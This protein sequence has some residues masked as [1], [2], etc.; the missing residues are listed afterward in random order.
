MSHNDIV[1][2]VATVDTSQCM[3][4]SPWFV[5]NTEYPPAV[6]TYKPLVNGEG[7][8][9]GGISSHRKGTK[10]GG[11]YLLGVSTIHVFYS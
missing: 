7:G 9:C 2:P 1:T 8:L 6:A 11:Y 4:T 5:Q 10:I 3:I